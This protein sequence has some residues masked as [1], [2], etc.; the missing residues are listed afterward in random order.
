M[1]RNF[2]SR[3]KMVLLLNL[4]VQKTLTHYEGLNSVGWLLMRL[5]V[6]EIGIGSGRKYY[7]PP[8][9][10]MRPLLYLLVPLKDII[11]FLNSIISAIKEMECFYISPGDIPHMIIRIS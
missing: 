6:L 5:P 10:I 7:V 8:L 1:I 4:R 3:L 2:L 11:I 9:Q